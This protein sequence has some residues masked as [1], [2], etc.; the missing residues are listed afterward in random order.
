[1]KKKIL[2]K[3]SGS[4]SALAF[5][6][7]VSAGTLNAATLV[8]DF[9]EG[10]FGTNWFDLSPAGS[11]QM[12]FTQDSNYL[13]N[14]G[15]AGS[16]WALG[17]GSYNDRDATQPGLLHVRSIAFALAA[18][19]LTL[20]FEG[21][22]ETT[23]APTLGTTALTTA[24]VT[25]NTMGFALTRVS[26]G[27]RVFAQRIGQRTNNLQTLTVLAADLA[28]FADGTTLYTLD[29][30]ESRDDVTFG[31]SGGWES[32]AI[33]NISVPVAVPE[34]GSLALVG[35]G[36]LGLILRRRRS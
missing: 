20:E 10:A 17:P 34:P 27:N 19:D 24:N 22:H 30:Y 26:D 16:E 33:D 9:N 1:M 21:G 32:F 14:T 36:G 4:V 6:A 35:L 18:G 3:K 13:N 12:M 29:F 23:V 7:L 25:P 8:F 28:T 2:A 11:N 31:T 5:M 15:A